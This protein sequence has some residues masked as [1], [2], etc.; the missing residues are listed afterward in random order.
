RADKKVSGSA[1][2]GGAPVHPLSVLLRVP[3]QLPLRSSLIAPLC[4]GKFKRVLPLGRDRIPVELSRVFDRCAPHHLS[5]TSR[6]QQL[7]EPLFQLSVVLCEET[8]FPIHNVV[9]VIRLHT[10]RGKAARCRLPQHL[11]MSL[12]HA[13]KKENMTA[14]HLATQLF[15]RE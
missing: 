9:R 4:Q 6:L 2:A 5:Q 3:Q 11:R 12:N 14:T 8:S 10:N 7:I 13:W 15:R 1:R